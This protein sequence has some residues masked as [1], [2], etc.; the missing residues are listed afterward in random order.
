MSTRLAEE[1]EAA[2]LRGPYS[3]LDKSG[4]AP[5]GDRHDYWSPSPYWWPDPDSKSGLP[6]VRRDGRRVPGSRLYDDLCGEFDRT[7]LQR[8][9]D[10]VT[11]LALAW[12][13]FGE[14]RYADHAARSIRSWFL[15]PRSAMNP[16]L[17]YAQVRRGHNRN[18]GFS[19]GVIEMK[20]LYYFLDAVR[21]IVRSGAVS[22]QEHA[23][24]RKWLGQYLKWLTT[25]TQGKKE[26]ATANNHGTYYDLQ[27]AAIGSFLERRRLVKKTVRRSRRRLAEQFDARGRQV[28]EIQRTQSLSYCS[29]NM[30]GWIHLARLAD[31]FGLDLWTVEGE[32]GRS[33]R[34]GMQW[35]LDYVDRPWP[36]TQIDAFDTQRF[37]PIAY[38]FHTIYGTSADTACVRV[39]ELDSIEPL[40]HPG[41]GI[42][43]FWQLFY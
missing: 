41:D 5:S 22:K 17:E 27:I 34:Q 15:D 43:P 20:D 19:S 14:E 4:C 10:D 31:G 32:H 37:H 1:A 29:F 25:S 18:K 39:P 21:V 11:I 40:F 42:R 30:Q 6:Y 24:F 23:Q 26:C 38:T 28:Y 16:S 35:L 2:M 7:R 12:E 36:Y 3:V 33:I 8:T 13:H 9:F